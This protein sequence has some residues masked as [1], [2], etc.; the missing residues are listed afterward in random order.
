MIF[1]LAIHLACAP[2]RCQAHVCSSMKITIGAYELEPFFFSNAA[3]QKPAS[4][5]NRR[6]PTTR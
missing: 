6:Y 3:A 2:H 1:T 5:G 4:A